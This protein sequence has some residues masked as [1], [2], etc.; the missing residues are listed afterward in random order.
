MSSSTKHSYQFTVNE[1]LLDGYGHVNNAKYLSL[2]ED[3]RWDILRQSGL[4]PEVVHTEKIGPIIL[5]VNIR[6]SREL[7]PGQL[8]TIET[9][10]TR[11]NDLVFYFNQVMLTESGEMASK[12]LFTAALFDLEK[13]KMV[14]PD[15]QWL[16]A[17]G[18][19]D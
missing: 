10:S 6:F 17:F 8:I 2:Y 19:V 15:E 13:R 11:K 5:E 18:I 7:L 12:A 16:K 14:K 1:D 9:I 4:G 3:A